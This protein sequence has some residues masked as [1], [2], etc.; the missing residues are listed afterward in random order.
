M[1]SQNFFSSRSLSSYIIEGLW[2][3]WCVASIIGIWPRFIEPYCLLTTHLSLELPKLPK[4]LKGLKILQFSD[5]HLH[6]AVPDFF[7]HR[8]LQK[9]ARLQPDLIAF[10]GDFLS[11][12]RL[13]KEGRLRNFL[14][15]LSAP[16]GCYAIL[17]NHDYS[18]FVSI[19]RKG[20]YDCIV[21][22]G[23]PI[24]KG[25]RRLLHKPPKLQKKTTKRAYKLSPHAE[26]V[27]ILH[28]TPF[29]LL[30]NENRLIDVKG[31]KLNICGLGE[32]MLGH[33]SPEE[34]FANYN[35]DYP[36]IVLTHNPDTFLLLQK[37]PGDII[38]AGHS[39]GGQI[40]LPGLWKRLTQMENME[41]HRGLF[42]F[43]NKYGYVNRGVGSSMKFRWFA[44][45][46]LLLLTLK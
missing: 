25:F 23:L 37:F 40:Y 15:S 45:P 31:S 27:E 8:I 39:H 29:Q 10:T 11:C 1:L 5:L 3:V 43:P 24:I 21:K 28:K 20:E 35:E 42:R 4:Q 22:E 9:I 6:N 33:C 18:H 2:D 17:G 36:G 13:P 38:L 32:Y 34:A 16:F 14:S 41:Y 30:H 46:E 26:L 19:N 44:P 7:L 12:S